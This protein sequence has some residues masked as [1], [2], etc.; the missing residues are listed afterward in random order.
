MLYV[1]ELSAL[2][3]VSVNTGYLRPPMQCL[4]PYQVVLL[5]RRFEHNSIDAGPLH[6][7]ALHEHF[8]LNSPFTLKNV[9]VILMDFKLN[10]FSLS[11][12][13]P[14]FS[15]LIQYPNKG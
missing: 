1:G 2:S 7:T 9:F 11:F 6:P 5:K 3:V 15:Y 14:H 13:P 8:D 4:C 12:I 10:F